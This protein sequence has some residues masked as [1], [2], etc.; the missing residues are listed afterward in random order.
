MTDETSDRIHQVIQTMTGSLT[1]LSAVA[2]D[3]QD[4]RAVFAADGGAPTRAY[5]GTGEAQGPNRAQN[6]VEAALAD[7]CSAMRAG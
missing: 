1:G 7:L 2:V 3:V 5:F 4:M 6:A